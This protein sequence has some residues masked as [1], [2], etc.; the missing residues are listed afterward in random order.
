MARTDADLFDL[1][2]SLVG[3][4]SLDWE[5]IEADPV[6]RTIVSTFEDPGTDEGRAGIRAQAL[7]EYLAHYTIR[8]RFLRDAPATNGPGT[9]H[10]ESIEST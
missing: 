3:L 5:R 2:I 6:F 10:I 7:Q 4:V 1:R 8:E 9:L